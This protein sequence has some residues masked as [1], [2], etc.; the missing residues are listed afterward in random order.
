[1][2][3]AIPDAFKERCLIGIIIEGRSMHQFSALTEDITGLDFGDKDI[4][5]AALVSGGRVAKFTPMAD[6]SMTLKV[7]PESAREDDG[8]GVVQHFHPQKTTA[9]AADPIAVDN[10]NLRNKHGIVLLWSTKLPA[11]AETVPDD[12]QPSYRIQVI[13]AYMT[14]YKPS[15]DDKVFGAEVTFKWTPFDKDGEP[16]KREESTGTA[17]QLPAAITTATSF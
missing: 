2:T 13:N 5:G 9:D 6:E 12:G 8:T 3:A 7:Y 4:E 17:T 10:T 16:N 15:F 1:M 11:T 14:G